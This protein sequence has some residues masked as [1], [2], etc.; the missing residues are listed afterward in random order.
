MIRKIIAGMDLFA[1]IFYCLVMAFLL[2]AGAA[3]LAMAIR[4]KC[5]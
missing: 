3:L 2:I 1:R 4:G 5:S